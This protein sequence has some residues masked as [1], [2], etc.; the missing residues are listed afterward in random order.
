[1][2]R[3]DTGGI[4]ISSYYHLQRIETI[5]RR[6]IS[7]ARSYGQSAP[8]IIGVVAVPGM[9]KAAQHWD[10]ELRT[11]WLITTLLRPRD[12]GYAP[13]ELGLILSR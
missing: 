7:F 4:F 13:L 1:V 6:K 12:M 8:S 2:L 11:W 9:Y 3:L 5:S 10:M